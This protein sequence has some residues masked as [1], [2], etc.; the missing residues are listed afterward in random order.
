MLASQQSKVDGYISVAGPGF[1]AGQV[2]REQLAAQPQDVIDAS[3]KILDK[4]ENGKTTDSIPPLLY[5][6]F[7]PSI[8]PYLISWFKYDPSV[9]IGKLKCPTL[10]I[11][12]TTDIQVKEKDALALK[13]GT[14]NGRLV[15]FKNMNHVLKTAPSDRMENIKTYSN[16]TLPLHKGLV[17][18][19]SKYLKKNS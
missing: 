10:I 2:I 13:M 18:S 1:T 17:K 12:G 3:S 14:S 19:I 5:A 4:L 16:P 9:E 6:L 15:L 8:Q 11:Q 7:R